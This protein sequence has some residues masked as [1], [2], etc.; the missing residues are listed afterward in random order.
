[1]LTAFLRI[2]VFLLVL[3]ASPLVRGQDRPFYTVIFGFTVDASGELAQFR[4]VSVADPLSG[5]EEPVDVPLPAEYVE[6]ARKLVLASHPEPRLENGRP[7]ETF[8]WYFYV[9]S[10][11]GRAD[12]DPTK[13]R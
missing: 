13:S 4:V 2:S 7:V 3:V 5:S 10:Q 8:T 6:A 11:P 12:L 9:P 1:M